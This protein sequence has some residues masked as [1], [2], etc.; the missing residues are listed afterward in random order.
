MVE[1]HPPPNA[2]RVGPTGPIPLRS[3][4]VTPASIDPP[5]SGP[6]P[7]PERR[8]GPGSTAGSASARPSVLARVVA[9][10][11]VVVSGACGAL[12]GYAVA[13]L[14][15]T[16]DCTV[17]TGL[18]AVFGGALAAFGVAVVVVLVLRAM[19]EWHTIREREGPPLPPKDRGPTQSRPRPRVQ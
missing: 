9:F 11:A 15:C 4:P 18:A 2:V 19:G 7:A 5:P 8:S 13:D 1:R 17:A 6:E 12:I 3:A 14:Q 16:G 10:A